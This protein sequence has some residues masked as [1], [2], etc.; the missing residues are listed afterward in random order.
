MEKSKELSCPLVSGICNI[1]SEKP[2]AIPEPEE[3]IKQAQFGSPKKPGQM[4]WSVFE[5]VYWI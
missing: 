4:P 5:D 2:A 3:K 1:R